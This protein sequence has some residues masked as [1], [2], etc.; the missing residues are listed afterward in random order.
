[1]LKK[2][3][4]NIYPQK[5][6]QISLLLGFCFVLYFVNLGQW[7][8]WNPDEPRYAQVTREMI[9]GGDWILMHFNGNVYTD[10]PPLFF[11]L[12]GLSSYLWQGF[13]SFAVRFPSAL[14]GTL[15]VLLTFFLGQRLYSSRTGFLSG[16]ILATSYQ[17]AFLATRANIDATLTFFTT[18]SLLFFIH[19]AQDGKRDQIRQ[20]QTEGISIYGFYI[21]MA[22]A[23]LAKG[24]VGFILPLFVSLIYLA[25]QRDWKGIKRMKLFPGM[26]LFIVIVF[27]WYGVAV[28]K[29]GQDYFDA[30]LFKHS[31]DRYSKGW[32]HIR[33]FYYYV[34]N[35]PA[36]FLPWIFFLPS[37]IVYG[38]SKET[39]ATRKRFL[40]LLV[41]CIV[42]FVFF[43]LSKGKR[44][45]YLLPL[46][47]AASLIVGKFWDD[48]ISHPMEN[49]RREWI[50]FPLYIFMG[51]TLIA[52]V[53]I[54]ALIVFAPAVIGF[55][56]L[57][58]IA[59]ITIPRII[60]DKW[61]SYLPQAVPMAFI[62]AGGS[63]ALFFLYRSKHYGAILF[64][65]V[66]MVAGGF[67]YTTRVVFPLVNPYKS[68]REICQEVKSRILPGEKLGIYGDLV[69][70]PY[71]FYTG[72]VPI[73]ELEKKEDLL[74]FLKSQDRVFCF[75]R[76]NDFDF[77]QS[78]EG[79][80]KV[81][82]IARQRIG[83]NDMALIS[84]RSMK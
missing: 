79:W 71:N 17:F 70:G 12:I 44:G 58:L 72:I 34:Y 82:L 5:W 59:G 48:I 2:P 3:F 56:G 9:D 18:G 43:S 51:L 8:L 27:S 67:F 63:L 14:F 7:D 42:I 74:Q 39:V 37:A 4:S 15:T 65:L 52:G 61:I 68:A 53:A 33:P 28:W 50:S 54:F 20:E 46:F 10:K 57:P 24:P 80:P 81:Q 77:F 55:M 83:N 26:L 47:P 6:A 64:L 49:F 25:I 11:W 78:M 32:S 38:Y 75:L 76:F 22:L 23:T 62:L 41:W 1:M 73:L 29:G 16:L 35:F 19:W 40:F 13:S 31:I 36:D 66:G 84:N 60:S 21:S 30:T 45:L 69:T